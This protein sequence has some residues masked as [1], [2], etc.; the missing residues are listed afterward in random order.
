MEISNLEKNIL[1][2]E[3]DPAT[4]SRNGN[5]EGNELA[6]SMVNPRTISEDSSFS[7][8]SASEMQTNG[9]LRYLHL[10]CDL[11]DADKDSE[12]D[13]A[14]SSP[15]KTPLA[16][17]S[18]TL[19]NSSRWWNTDRW[20]LEDVAGEDYQSLQKQFGADDEQGGDAGKS[21]EMVE[22]EILSRLEERMEDRQNG[23]GNIVLG[24]LEPQRA[25]RPLL[26]FEEQKTAGDEYENERR[27]RM[28]VTMA[29]L[30]TGEEWQ[31]EDFPRLVSER[32]AMDVYLHEEEDSA[33]REQHGQ[34]GRFQ[35]RDLFGHDVAICGPAAKYRSALPPVLTRT[36]T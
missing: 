15:G 30:D 8:K 7:F 9:I 29:G 31:D 3:P 23:S 11:S 4:I 2:N 1:D 21:G 19:R 25:T 10:T 16:S 36:F 13:E 12:D 20:A 24:S 26:L 14:R 34:Q 27:H 28:V 5:G 32:L 17:N 33:A 18:P 22:K 35:T 6:D